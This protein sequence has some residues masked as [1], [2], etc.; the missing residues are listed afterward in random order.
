MPIWQ[1]SPVAAEPQLTLS[2]WQIFETDN[3]TRHFVGNDV[4]SNTGRV[5]SAISQFDASSRR[6]VTCSGRVYQLRGP[7]GYC[8]D[9]HYVWERWCK[10]NGV[11]SYVDVTSQTL[12]E[13]QP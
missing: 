2:F 9:A 8:E 3:G 1:A 6:G 12:E 13:Q 11:K 5:S 4:R 10:W 7:F